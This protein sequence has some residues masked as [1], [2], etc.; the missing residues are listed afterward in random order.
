MKTIQET[1][2]TFGVSTRT[3][4]Y[5]EEIGLLTPVRSSGNQRMYSKQ[6]ETRLKLIFRG[7]K[8]GFSLEEIREM[9]LLFDEDRTGKK[10]LERTIEYGEARV[11][12]IE[13][14]IQEFQALK[15]EMEHLL[16]G[17]KQKLKEE[18]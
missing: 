3:L 14:S 7:K 1:A 9:V 8:Y 2:E 18:Q 5:Y 10:Q 12:E 4:R 16:T 15:E 6:D 13:A 17:F 11:Q